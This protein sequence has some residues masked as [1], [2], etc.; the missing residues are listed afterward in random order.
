MFPSPFTYSNN[1][2][3][4]TLIE[5]RMRTLSGQI[6]DK[7]QWWE[8]VHDTT[9]TSKW[10]SE[11][12]AQDAILVDELWGGEKAKDD[13]SGE[14]R[15]PKD[16]INDAQLDCI[17][18]EL[19]WFA[20]QRDEQTGIQETM[21]P[22]VYHSTALI[23]SYL[24]SALI[25]AASNL[26]SV[27]PQ[28]Q[29]WHPGSNGQ[30]LDLVHPSLYCL[31]ID[32]SLILKTLEDGSKT[33]YVS[34]LENYEALRPDLDT[35]TFAASQ[36]HQWLPTDFKVSADGQVE[37]LGYINNLHTIDQKPLYEIIPSVLQRFIPLFERVLSDS[38]G[39]DRP[40]AVD[41]DTSTWYDHITVE[42]PDYEELGYER[43]N[44]A[45]VEWN[46]EHYWPY[47]PDPYPFSPPLPDER[48]AF[49]LKG[50]TVQVIV[51][52]ANIVLTP[53]KPK[54]PG[55]SWHVEGMENER[56]VAT[57]IYY[58]TS[59]NI[60]ESKLGFRTAIGD[61][62]S[63]CMLPYQQSDSKGYTVA[64]GITRDGALNQK[65]GSVIAKED[66]CLAFPNIYQHRVAP[67]ELVDATKPGV[68]KILCFFLVDPT[69]KILSTSD[70][71]PQQRRWYEDELAKI[72]ALL[73][74][75]VELQDII[76]DYTLA[77]KITLEQAQEERELLME[78]RAGFQVEH[79]EKV[80]EMQF[81]MCEH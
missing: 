14:K 12:I 52:M 68:R 54:Y 28:E 76:K 25:K 23:P 16:K 61:G 8:K 31:R 47:I 70:V 4:L 77:E 39:P 24:K 33:T 3:P 74:L 11:A 73:N 9:I 19:K 80:F 5:L 62:T 41:P 49:E 64:F 75:P 55:G 26:E 48:I 30:V 34:S 72:P 46:A 29:D 6:R 10:R 18:E 40:L 1:N 50:Q 36:Q 69:T 79:N 35:N 32:D 2:T 65:L 51:K 38:A 45:Y 57:G 71:P 43:W 22:K 59:T 42:Q 67:F 37:P 27:D 17:F 13:G 15:W 56:I 63:D 78:E 44:K 20:T 21:I 58:Y 66:K 81:N 60:S 7:P 53:D